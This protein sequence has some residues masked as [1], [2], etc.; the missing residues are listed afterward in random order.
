MFGG[1]QLLCDR[2][3]VAPAGHNPKGRVCAD[4][5]SLSIYYYM[6]LHVCRVASIVDVARVLSPG[7][8]FWECV[9]SMMNCS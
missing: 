9:W 1:C 4:L 8:V 7:T 5:H 6:G 2:L 3:C